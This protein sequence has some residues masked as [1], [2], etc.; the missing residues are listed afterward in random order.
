[1]SSN[2]LCVIIV[3][4]QCVNGKIKKKKIFHIEN[5]HIKVADCNFLY[6]VISIVQKIY[7]HKATNGASKWISSK[8][9]TLK[10]FHVRNFLLLR[11]R[12]ALEDHSENSTTK[13][14]TLKFFRS[15]FEILTEGK[16]TNFIGVSRE[17]G[18]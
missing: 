2:Q 18:K 5:W 3:S 11:S 12:Y 7:I 14:D 10:L 8:L 13:I 9:A 15:I 17:K 6:R 4:I 1:M 16:R